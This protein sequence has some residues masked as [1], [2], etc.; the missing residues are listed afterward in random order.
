[1]KAEPSATTLAAATQDVA[2]RETSPAA[3]G[4]PVQ[5]AWTEV[6]GWRLHS[7]HAGRPRPGVP[8][9]VLLHGLGVSSLYM[10]PTA[11]LLG[12]RFD[13]HA[14]DL[15]GF[16]RS[17]KPRRVLSIGELADA[18]AA[19]LEARDLEPPVLLAN[20]MGCQ[21]AVEYMIRHGM[22]ARG[23][24]LVGPTVDR[25]DRSAMG[26]FGRLL[27]DS[28]RETPSQILVVAYDYLRFGPWRLVRTFRSA[29]Q[30]PIE[31]TLPRIT[32][33]TLVVRGA[34]DPIAPQRWCEELAALVPL[35]RLAVVAGAAHTVNYMAPRALTEL[36]TAF[37]GELTG[38]RR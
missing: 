24:V 2:A 27:L 23:L 3:E 37:V 19:W 35:G 28:V 14:P 5:S 6:S 36:T 10:V 4:V 34:R 33:P 17:S 15:P 11:R 31:R 21:I 38:H 1:M 25:A 30:H 22:R 29:Q 13:V 20:S 9:I 8:P 16:G 18:L 12:A 26:Q 32:V 7:R